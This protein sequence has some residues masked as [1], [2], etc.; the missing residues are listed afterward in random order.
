MLDVV[1]MWKRG[2]V[3]GGGGGGGEVVKKKK[4]R[5]FFPSLSLSL[6]HFFDLEE[7]EN[8]FLEGHQVLCDTKRKRCSTVPVCRRVLGRG[9][10]WEITE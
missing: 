3:G 9:L 6:S 5:V 2:V 7:S 4:G 1:R 10:K 8:T